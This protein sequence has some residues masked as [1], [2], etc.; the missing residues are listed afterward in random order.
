MPPPVPVHRHVRLN[1]HYRGRLDLHIRQRFRL[2]EMPRPATGQGLRPRVVDA[3]PPA[4][5]RPGQR[6]AELSLLRLRQR[7]AATDESQ[8]A[9]PVKPAKQHRLRSADR[10]G[11]STDDRLRVQSGRMRPVGNTSAARRET[12]RRA[13]R[14]VRRQAPGAGYEYARAHVPRRARSQPAALWRES[15]AGRGEGSGGPGRRSCSLK[16]LTRSGVR[17]AEATGSW[18]A[19]FSTMSL[20]ATLTHTQPSASARLR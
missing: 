8:V 11:H 19:L 5:R 3:D 6:R 15:V 20:A 17:P 13:R 14:P 18:P 9:V 10:A 12:R 16:R 4:L 1:V 7:M 2:L